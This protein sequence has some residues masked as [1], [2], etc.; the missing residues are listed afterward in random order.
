MNT[1]AISL[2]DERKL[3]ELEEKFDPEMRFRPTVPPA[4]QLVKWMLISLSC[5]HYYTAG[6]GLLQEITHRSVLLA[7][8]LSMI[9][10]VFAWS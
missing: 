3:Q 5:F 6:F 4:T 9:F 10:L 7:F 1:P 8:V 2:P